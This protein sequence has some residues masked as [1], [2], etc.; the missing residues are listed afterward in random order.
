[1]QA[2]AACIRIHASFGQLGNPW[3]TIHDSA[4]A[5]GTLYKSDVRFFF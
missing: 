4:A 2:W 3:E 5:A 1:M